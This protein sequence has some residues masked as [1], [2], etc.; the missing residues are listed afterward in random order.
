MLRTEL[1]EERGE[2]LLYISDESLVAS[3]RHL[4]RHVPVLY[5]D[6]GD[7]SEDAGLIRTENRLNRRIDGDGLDIGRP[8]ANRAR[9]LNRVAKWELLPTEV[10]ATDGRCNDR[11][12][13]RYRCAGVYPKCGTVEFEEDGPQVWN[14]GRYRKG[15]WLS[16]LIP[17]KSLKIENEGFSAA[18]H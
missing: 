12:F 4:V 3:F 1:R 7:A 16:K 13:A 2:S 8:P 9:Y 11:G 17:K 18:R 14:D 5:P 6:D 10:A 15:S